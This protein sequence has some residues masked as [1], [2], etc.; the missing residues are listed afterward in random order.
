MK[1]NL[2]HLRRPAIAC[3]GALTCI[4]LTACISTTPVW[5]K[6]VG[7]AVSAVTRAQ[8]IDPQ[9]PAGLPPMQGGDGKSAVAAMNKYDRSLILLPM[10][11]SGGYGA[12]D[13]GFG[14]VGGLSG[15]GGIGLN[16]GGM[17]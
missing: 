6:H 16:G 8:I 13:G 7:E 3:L 1:T 14:A 2:K 15:M 17:R 11:S 10:G 5:D 12:S 9:A 4:M